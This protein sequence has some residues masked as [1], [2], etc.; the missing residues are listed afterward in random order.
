VLLRT[1]CRGNAP[2][3]LILFEHLDSLLELQVAIPDMAN[4][5]TMVSTPRAPREAR[6]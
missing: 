2:V 1:I 5:V 6:H 4:L 3:Q